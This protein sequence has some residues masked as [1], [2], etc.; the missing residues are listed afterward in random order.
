MGASDF[1]E[2]PVFIGLLFVWHF[3]NWNN[4]CNHCSSLKE[5]LQW[6]LLISM[7]G[8]DEPISWISKKQ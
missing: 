8:A 3:H 5:S 1:A 6:S 2:T 4:D 7:T